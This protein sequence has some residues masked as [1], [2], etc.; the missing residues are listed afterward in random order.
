[1]DFEQ[2]SQSFAEFLQNNQGEDVKLYNV[3]Q[4]SKTTKRVVVCSKEKE[5]DCKHLAKSFLEY[6][7]GIL[8]PTHVDGIFKGEWVVFDFEDIIVHI[9]TDHA[10]QKYNLDKMYKDCETLEGDFTQL[11]F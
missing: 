5:A 1:M 3:E 2:I 4:K 11:K 6:A 10:K 7:T 8:K 9:I